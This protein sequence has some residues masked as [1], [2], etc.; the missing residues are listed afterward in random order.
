MPVSRVTWLVHSHYPA[1]TIF[2]VFKCYIPPMS[3]SSFIRFSSF[4]HFISLSEITI[5]CLREDGWKDWSGLDCCCSSFTLAHSSSTPRSKA[6]YFKWMSSK[7]S[8]LGVSEF[9]GTNSLSK[10]CVKNRNITKLL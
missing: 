7:K 1:V 8:G 10:D 5:C 3:F 6:I 9:I 2:K 4:I